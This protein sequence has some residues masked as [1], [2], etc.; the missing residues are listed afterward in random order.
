MDVDE[1]IQG[2][3]IQWSENKPQKRNLKEVSL[4]KGQRKQA[5][6]QGD[7]EGAV[8]KGEEGEGKQGNLCLR[9]CFSTREVTG[10]K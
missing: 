5:V 8:A 9:R 6:F 2:E 1:V 10:Q 3:S 4:R 7:Q